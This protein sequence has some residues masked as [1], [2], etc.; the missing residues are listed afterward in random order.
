MPGLGGGGR[1]LVADLPWEHGGGG[2][3]PLAPTAKLAG[4]RREPRGCSST[5][6]PQPSKL[7]MGVR[8]PSPAHDV[9]S[10]PREPRPPSPLESCRH[11]LVCHIGVS[12]QRPLV[13][14][15]PAGLEDGRGA[16]G[17]EVVDVPLSSHPWNDADVEDGQEARRLSRHHQ[18][19][20]IFLRCISEPPPGGLM[21]DPSRILEEL[22]RGPLRPNPP[23]P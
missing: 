23:A 10:P 20:E 6:E 7:V 19:D 14:V 13:P 2:F 12:P 21:L 17:E 1:R 5:V 22:A 11:G 9:L 15:P 8:F 4:S 16:G 18:A 3:N